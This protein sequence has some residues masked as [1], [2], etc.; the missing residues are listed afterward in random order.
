MAVDRV[1][2]VGS[3]H[4]RRLSRSKT[5]AAA[6]RRRT[7]PKDGYSGKSQHARYRLDNPTI[8]CLILT[9]CLAEDC[10]AWGIAPS[11]DL[12]SLPGMAWNRD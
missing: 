3:T 11:K 12:P 5:H 10:K 1:A 4:R 2:V 8:V 6:L 7:A 9:I